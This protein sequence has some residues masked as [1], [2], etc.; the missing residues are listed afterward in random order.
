MLCVAPQRALYPAC[1]ALLPAGGLH[2][3]IVA[4][5]N[6]YKDKKNK[7]GE[8]EGEVDGEKQEEGGGDDKENASLVESLQKA[9]K[10]LVGVL[11]GQ[12]RNVTSPRL[13]PHHLF[14]CACI[15]RHSTAWLQWWPTCK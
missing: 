7:Q 3:G 12:V 2:K 4:G 14:V 9:E 10:I 13:H 6:N 1:I 11:A 8:H 15:G 5:G